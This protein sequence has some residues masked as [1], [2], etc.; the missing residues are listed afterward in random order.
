[1]I[2]LLGKSGAYIERSD[3]TGRLFNGQVRKTPAFSKDVAAYRAAVA[4]EDGY[5]NLVRPYKSLRLLAE[6]GSLRKRLPRTPAMAAELTDHIWAVKE[7]LITL[8]IPGV[9]NA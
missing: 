8:P 7:L 5:Y 4:W 2:A 6:D 9:N 1:M 3:L